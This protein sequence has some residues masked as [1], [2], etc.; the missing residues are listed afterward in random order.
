MEAY[1]NRR[2]IQKLQ[3]QG[4]PA[5]FFGDNI[6]K[7]TPSLDDTTI[8]SASTVTD[9]FSGTNKKIS[10]I[11]NATLESGT[12]VAY[13]AQENE[14]LKAQVSNM[15]KLLPKCRKLSLPKTKHLPLGP[16]KSPFTTREKAANQEVTIQ[17]ASIIVGVMALPE[18]HITLVTL[19]A[20]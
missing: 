2:K 9:A 1:E 15:Q 13:M 8:T 14:L 12:Q 16:P 6:K 5:Q 7:D 3:E 10:A 19:A 17:I 20:N 11:A 4:S 18:L